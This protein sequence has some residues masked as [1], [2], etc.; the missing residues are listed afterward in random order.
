MR[1]RDH[2]ERVALSR[3]ETVERLGSESRFEQVVRNWWRLIG[4][5]RNLSFIL[6]VMAGVSASLLL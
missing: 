1:F 6:K 3:G 5:Q 2:V 4:A